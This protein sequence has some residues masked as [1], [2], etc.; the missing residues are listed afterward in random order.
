MSR[1][2]AQPEVVA[3]LRVVYIRDANCMKSLC[4]DVPVK[5]C[6]HNIPAA[7]LAINTYTLEAQPDFLPSLKLLVLNHLYQEPY[8]V[9]ISVP[10]QRAVAVLL[11]SPWRLVEHA[12][13]VHVVFVGVCEELTLSW[14]EC[15]GVG[16]RHLEEDNPKYRNPP[17]PKPQLKSLLFKN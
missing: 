17:L 16:G 15:F 8:L 12:Q 11:Q 2:G 7:C 10:P 5:Y 1:L 13:I 6:R 14:V 9:Q 4:G 3:V